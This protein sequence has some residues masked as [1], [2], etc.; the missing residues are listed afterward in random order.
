MVL[1]WRVAAGDDVKTMLELTREFYAADE[2]PFDVMTAGR[3]LQDL[4]SNPALGRAWLIEVGGVIAG[5]IVVTYCFSLEFGGRCVL[6]DELYVRP[7]FEGRGIARAALDFVEQES[8]AA[9]A[10]ALHLEVRMDNE[11]ARRLYERAGFTARDNHLM[12]K[13]L[14][15]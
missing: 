10:H 6:I 9:G 15:R 1:T 13:L 12:S 5:Y 3:S 11:R 4:V 8:R 7:T 2:I 14:Q